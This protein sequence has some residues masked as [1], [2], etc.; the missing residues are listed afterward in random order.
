MVSSG[1]SLAY[2]G[3]LPLSLKR[4]GGREGER[5]WG[6]ACAS[7]VWLAWPRP[8]PDPMTCLVFN[9]PAAWRAERVRV[10]SP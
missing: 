7:M 5:G 1:C 4:Y 8:L 10:S 3:L 2:R 6:T 9:P